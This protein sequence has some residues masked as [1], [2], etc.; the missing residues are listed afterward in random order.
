MN[1]Y[2]RTSERNLFKRCQWAWERNYIDQIE[3]KQRHSQALWFGTG[4]HLALEKWYIPGTK[5]GVHPVETWNQYCDESAA[6]TDYINTYVDGDFSEAIKAR[7]LGVGMLNAYLEEY[8]D[9][10]WMDIVSPE[11]TFQ[12]PLTHPNWKGEGGSA[13][14]EPGKTTYVGTFDLV[15]RDTR[16]GKLYVLDHKTARALGSSNTQYLPL[17]DQAGAYWAMAV[18]TLREQGL[19]GGDEILTGIVY[20]YLVKVKPDERPKNK[21]GFATNL[22]QKKHYLAALSHLNIEK[23]DKLKVDELKCKAEEHGIEVFGEVS[24]RQPGKAF[25]RVVV[26]KNPR[27]QTKQIRRMIQDLESM[28]LVR[29]KVV[30][31][32]KSPAKECSFCPFRDICELDEAGRDYSDMKEMLFTS[33]DPY[34]AHRTDKEK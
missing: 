4:I 14:R 6:D 7:D 32:T 30:A 24:S 26:R 33:W 8:G 13:K 27:Q 12:V 25:E 19:I 11:L 31:A 34:S 18:Y 16:D 5:R 10:P 21:D 2:L 9:E 1:N 29:N 17:D 20:N 22:P 23:L 15:Y 28:S 3:P